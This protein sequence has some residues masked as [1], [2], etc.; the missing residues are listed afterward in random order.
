MWSI[1]PGSIRILLHWLRLPDKSKG[2]VCSGGRRY[3][4][5]DHWHNLLPD[6][7][8]EYLAGERRVRFWLEWDR[9]MMGRR[10][11]VAKFTTYAQNM[12][13]WEWFKEKSVLPHLL[14]VA[15]GMDQ[16]MRIARVVTHVLA[17]VP[18]L[19][20]HSTTATRLAEWG[21]LAAI[22]YQVLPNA[23]EK[24]TAARRRLYDVSH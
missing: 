20:V 18:G 5:H 8:G 3:R 21:P 1:L 4:D 23:G 17:T 6:A 10:D 22:W 9:A 11:L 14:V 19:V 16:E 7:V 12:T 2:I 15:P 24:E 13:S